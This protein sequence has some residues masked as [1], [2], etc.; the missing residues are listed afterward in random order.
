MDFST[1]VA[2]IGQVH[3]QSAAQANR[4]INVSLTLRNWAIGAYIR[5]YEQQGTDRA[6]YG[7]QLLERLSTAL[8]A[9]LDRCYSGRYL[10]L[11]RQLFDVYPAIRKSVISESA[12]LSL[13]VHSSLLADPPAIQKSAIS[14][15]AI[16][17]QLVVERLSFTHLVEL[18]AIADPLKR[19]FYE[20]ECIR[21]NWAVRALKRQIDTLYFERSAL[22]RDKEKLAAMVR[23]GIEAAEP[24][25]AIRDPYIF[26][27]LGL[28]AEDSIAE[29]D[30]EGWP[31]A[32]TR[33]LACCCAP[34]GITPWLNTP[35]RAWTTACSSPNTSSNCP[36]RTSCRSFW[37]RSAGNLTR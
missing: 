13:P 9:N 14:G 12:W 11:C 36:A 23:Q 29:S 4:V 1:L 8:Q 27:F 16:D 30:L 19:A 5:S 33:R 31:R 15:F 3:A 21:G 26:E 6:Q 20:I 25:L 7:A 34:T 17:P 37:K 28:R 2:A 18:I 35:P 24:R 22:S 32:T 10:G